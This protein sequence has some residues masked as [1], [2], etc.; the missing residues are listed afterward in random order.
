MIKR[1]MTA[2]RQNLVAWLALFVALGGTSVAVSHYVITSTSQIK[3]TVLRKLRGAKGPAGPAGPPGP[4]GSPAT[5]Y[6]LAL[7]GLTSVTGPTAVVQPGAVKS[8]TALCPPGSR[9]VS[10]GGSGGVADINISEMQHGHVGWFIVVVNRTPIR[11]F[12]H[13]EA[14]CSPAGEAVAARLQGSRAGAVQEAEAI[15]ERLGR[16]LRA[17]GR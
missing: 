11:E 16:E 7:K 1:S 3:P 2:I 13:A 9:A 10:G 17:A 5:V 4:P 14:Q 8:A 15:A 12:I 6:Q